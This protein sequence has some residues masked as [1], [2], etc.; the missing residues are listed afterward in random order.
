MACIDLPAP[1]I[2]VLGFGLS[3]EPPSTPPIDFDL[4]LCCKIAAIHIPA[5]PLPL[6]P[7]TV[8]ASTQAITDAVMDAIQ[9]FLDALPLECPKE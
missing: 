1:T 3:L 9:Q 8:N 2:P 6:P 5:F 7:F 4:T